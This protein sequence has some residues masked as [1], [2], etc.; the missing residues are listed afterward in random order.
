[1]SLVVV[2]EIEIGGQNVL[3]ISGLYEPSPEDPFW[4][5]PE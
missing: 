4:I 2:E 5:A 3:Y 1:M